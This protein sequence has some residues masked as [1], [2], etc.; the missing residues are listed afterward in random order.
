[1][2]V[3]RKIGWRKAIGRLVL[4]TLVFSIVYSIVMIVSTT[5]DFQPRDPD[6]KL[7][8]DYVLMLVQCVLAT[9]VMLLPSL[10]EHR[11]KIEIPN[12]MYIAFVI[13][14]YC[15]VYLGEV[16]SF[17]YLIPYW[18][19]ILH[20]FSGAML[21]ALGF[22][23][24][25]L[26]NESDRVTLNM[27]PLFIALFTFCFAVAMGVLWEIYE[28][29]V[30]GVL[31]LNMQKAYLED[32]TPLIGREALLDTM[33]DLIVDVMGAFVMSLAGFISLSKTREWIKNFKL[34][35]RK[36]PPAGS[37]PLDL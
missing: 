19:T 14:L 4:L 24:V 6:A 10:I 17:Y 15:G 31:H 34:K 13:F 11:A 9:G 36:G 5:N 26:L 33:K 28:F 29:S 35:R 8:S 1:M 20:A 25:T 16:R 3:M 21:G 7:R 30:D 27:N 32:G 22:T 23:L 18:D 12:G 2:A 37:R